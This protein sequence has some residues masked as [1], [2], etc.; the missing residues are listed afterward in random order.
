MSSQLPKWMMVLMFGMS[1]PIPNAVVTITTLRG[2]E[3]T[4]NALIICDRPRQN[5]PYC[6]ENDF[7]VKATITEIDL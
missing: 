1:I 3:S 6:G 5:Q 7:L 4:E 2:E